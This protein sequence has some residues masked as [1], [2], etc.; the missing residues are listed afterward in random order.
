M[1]DILSADRLSECQRSAATWRLRYEELHRAS[2]SD[3]IDLVQLQA[4]R[5]DL[6]LDDAEPDVT[7]D[8][9][10]SVLRQPQ[11]QPPEGSFA[12]QQLFRTPST[13]VR[14][15]V[16]QLPAGKRL[17]Y[18]QMLF[19][20]QFAACCDEAWE[21]DKNLLLSVRFAICCFWEQAAPVKHT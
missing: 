21:N 20:V 8:G 12:E 11:G 2:E 1:Q 6:N 15:L 7:H 14:H 19:M 10:D 3:H 4:E 17:T 9:D 18:D 16:E 5:L 13:Y